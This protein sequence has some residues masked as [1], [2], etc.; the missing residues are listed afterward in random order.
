MGAVFSFTSTRIWR[1]HIW[2][3]PCCNNYQSTVNQM[4]KRGTVWECFYF[5]ENQCRNC[6]WDGRLKWTTFWCFSCRNSCILQSTWN[7]TWFV[8]LLS[9]SELLY[10][11]T[12]LHIKSSTYFY[13]NL[14]Y[15]ISCGVLNKIYYVVVFMK[16]AC[17]FD[18]SNHLH[19]TLRTNVFVSF[20]TTAFYDSISFKVSHNDRL[21][22]KT[23]Q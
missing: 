7:G 17:F 12:I 3:S 16:T 21:L 5:H 2:C 23:S 10:Y 4:S 11:L 22:S 8:H 6:Q 9:L 13:S 19:W 15:M 18:G 1:A 20:T 14:L